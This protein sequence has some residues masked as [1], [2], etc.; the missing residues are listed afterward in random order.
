MKGTD[1]EVKVVGE[2][3]LS[4]KEDHFFLINCS[5]NRYFGLK[6]IHDHQT[7]LARKR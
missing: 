3:P 7:E 5:E 4:K 2:D 6:S 1:E